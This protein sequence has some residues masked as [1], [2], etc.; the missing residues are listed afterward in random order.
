MVMITD[1]LYKLRH[2]I[3]ELGFD[4]NPSGYSVVEGTPTLEAPVSQACTQTQMGSEIYAQHCA[5][6]KEKPWL[7]RKQ[8]EF[9]YIVQC[10]SLHDM[11]KPGR[12][13][14]GFGVGGEPLPALFA[15]MGVRVLGTDLDPEHAEGL[16]W[17]ETNQHAASKNAMN[18]RGI[19]SPEEFERLVS[20]RSMDMNAIAPDT[21]GKFD[22]CW[23]A[24][25]L[26]HLG[27]IDKGLQFIENSIACLRPGGLAV[28][29]TEYNCSSN[30]TTLDNTSTVLFRRRDFEKLG[31][32]L[33]RKGHKVSFNFGTGDQPAD[34]H[35]DVPPYTQEPHLKLQI[36]EWTTTSFGIMVR[37]AD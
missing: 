33:A 3:G 24:C 2:W 20:F 30:T 32:Y 6:L 37:K 28:H 35:I 22:F 34:Q 16:G 36:A 21:A 15:K 11:L 23:S 17:I 12:S 8:W 29:T 18:N 14:I 9:V 10:L 13:G 7:H 31:K 5:K 1:R 4:K 27:S 26:E 19:C 25:A